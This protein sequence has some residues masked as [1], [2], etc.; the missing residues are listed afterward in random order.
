MSTQI[1]CPNLLFLRFFLFSALIAA[2]TLAVAASALAGEDPYLSAIQRE[3]VKVDQASQKTLENPPA[4]TISEGGGPSI[5]AFEEDLKT[6]YKGSYA[7]YQRL[8]R[9]TQEEIFEE[10]RQGASIGE[11][12]Q[13]IMDRF[14]NR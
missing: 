10:Y 4:S 9:R 13:K 14:L 1:G 7:F 2:L 8:P 11:I 6:G 5:D 3:A 12:R